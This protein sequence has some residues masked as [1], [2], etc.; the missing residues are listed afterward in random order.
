VNNK[1]SAYIAHVRSDAPKSK[2]SLATHLSE[3]GQLAAEFASKIGLENVGAVLGLLHDF[4]KYAREFQTY[5]QSATHYIEQDDEDWVDAKLLRG[6]ID[7]S[8]AGAQ[9]VWTE[10]SNIATKVG[11]GEMCGQILAL[12]IASHHSGLI[13][14]LNED[15]VDKNG[16]TNFSRRMAKLDDKTHL[17]E[18]IK[19]ADQSIRSDIDKRLTKALV[20]EMF[21]KIRTMITLSNSKDSLLSKEDAFTLGLFTRFLFS[22]LIDADRLNSAEFETP[23]NKAHRLAQQRYFS[24]EIAI[25]R[26]D[27]KLQSFGGDKPIDKVRSAISDSCFHRSADAPGIYTL[28]VPTGGGKTFA[29]LRYALNH[30][31]S[32]NMDR[33]I[34]IIPYTSIIE[35]NAEAVRDIIEEDGDRFPWVLEHHGNIEPEK[36]TW[37]SKLAVENWDAPIV[38]TTMVQFLEVLFSGG[39]RGVRRMHQLANTVLIFDEIQTLPINCVHMFSNALNFLSHHANTTALLCTATQPLLDKLPNSEYGLIKLA[40]NAELVDDKSQL[41]ADLKRVDI[42]NRCKPG[43][44]QAEEIVDLINKR[45]QTTKSCLVIVNTKAWAK[46]LFEALSNTV[47]S[48]ALFHLSTNQCAAHRKILFTKIKQRLL[49]GSPVLCVSTQLI[50]AGVDVDFAHVVRFLAG[51]DSIAQAAGRCNRNGLL[52]DHQ[53][54]LLSGQVDVVDPAEGTET[55]NNLVDIVE[56]KVSS[57][58]IFDEFEQSELLSPQAMD[59]YYEDFFFKRQR[60]MAYPIDRDTLFNLLAN[61]DKNI[62]SGINKKRHCQGK[63]PFLQ[64]SFMA[65]GKAFKAIDAPTHS[66]IVP[67]GEGKEIIEELCNVNKEFNAGHFYRTLKR[68]QQYSVNVFPNVWHKLQDSGYVNEIQDEGIYFLDERYYSENYGLS[69]TTVSLQQCFSV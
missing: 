56:G 31:K 50:E 44:W 34:Y 61:N 47:D 18:A 48:D 11:Q 53:G 64:Q 63:L 65:A 23:D 14:C 12:C 32:H 66:V 9:Y 22:C 25:N 59:A 6:K 46:T 38:F 19:N 41:F 5:I 37:R 49:E 54:K 51:L 60:D 28:S 1:T 2:Q 24:W 4:G 17:N 62:G 15:G 16:K 43:G 67:Y 45:Y 36:Q 3:T 55:I 57:R 29:S 58:R 27:R 21:T 69:D 20:V 40:N 7:H 13:D 8:T 33:I 30:A 10:L 39:T 42:N 35:Q 26:L 68:A 52:T